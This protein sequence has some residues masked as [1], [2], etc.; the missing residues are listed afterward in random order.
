MQVLHQG[1]NDDCVLPLPVRSAAS[2]N[3]HCRSLLMRKLEVTDAMLL[4]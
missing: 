3:S 1:L 4:L 2:D